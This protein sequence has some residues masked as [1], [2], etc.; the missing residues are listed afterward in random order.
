MYLLHRKKPHSKTVAT[1]GRKHAM[2]T[3]DWS[4]A[5]AGTETPP[6]LLGV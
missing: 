2:A 5:A 3:V 4:R 6:L 1:A